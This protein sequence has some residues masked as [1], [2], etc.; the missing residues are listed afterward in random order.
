MLN[1]LDHVLALFSRDRAEVSVLDAAAVLKWPRSTTY[2]LLAQIAAAGFLD[3]DEETGM[4]RL[5]IR[6]AVLGELAQASTSLQRIAQPVLRRLSQ[7]SG[8]TATLLLL[9]DG[10][11]TAVLHSESTHP[12]VAKGMLG[13]YWPLHASAGGKVLLAWR[14]PVEAKRLLKT[15]LAR[16]TPSTIT[17]VPALVRELTQVRKRGFATVRGEFIDGVWGVA[18]P[19]FN[20]R[21]ELEGAVTLGGPSSR[22][23]RARLPALAAIVAGVGAELSTALG[24]R[25]EYPYATDSARGRRSGRAAKPGRSGARVRSSRAAPQRRR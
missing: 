1:Q 2:R 5:G 15:P 13:R 19:I 25:G 23:T 20:H 24:Y 17:S 3:R 7:Q 8:E 22:V 11:G 18:V 21:G 9:V 12:V 4:F 6:L 16:F 10:E 14:P